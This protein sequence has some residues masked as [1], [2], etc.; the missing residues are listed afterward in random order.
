MELPRVTDGSDPR[1]GDQR[2]NSLDRHQTPGSLVRAGALGDPL[3]V[4][5]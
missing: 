3:V 5:F 2:T 1:G 4:P